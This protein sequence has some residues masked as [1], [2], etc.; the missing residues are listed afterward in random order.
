MNW[1]PGHIYSLFFTKL[2][3]IAYDR[4]QFPEKKD[5]TKNSNNLKM[6][7]KFWTKIENNISWQ[8]RFQSTFI[9][10]IILQNFYQFW[11]EIEIKDH[12]RRKCKQFEICM[13]NKIQ[14][15]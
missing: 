1:N 9:Y 8:I 15:K 4:K 12:A 5:L 6:N 14:W 11:I 2:R 13:I 10:E 7:M 3:E